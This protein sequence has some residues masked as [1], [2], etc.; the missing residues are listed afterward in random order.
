[1]LSPSYVVSSLL[2]NDV[3]AFRGYRLLMGIILLSDGVV[4]A[5]E[6][7]YLEREESHR[8]LFMIFSVM[9]FVIYSGEFI[10]KLYINKWHFL[11]FSGNYKLY[12]DTSLVYI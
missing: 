2:I 6:A 11:N 7:S 10:C 1:M 3:I 5:T 12:R 9:F 4:I 8:T